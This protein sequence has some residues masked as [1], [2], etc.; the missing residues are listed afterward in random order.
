MPAD[1]HGSGK[2][3]LMYFVSWNRS[4][5]LAQNSLTYLNSSPL[6]LG[7]YFRKCKFSVDTFI[8]VWFDVV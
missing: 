1:C 6:L 4:W 8:R 7:V 2:T 5:G 3:A